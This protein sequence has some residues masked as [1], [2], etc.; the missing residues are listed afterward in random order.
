MRSIVIILVAAA[1]MGASSGDVRAA[2]HGPFGIGAV[3][4]DPT[5]VTGKLYFGDLFA[6]DFAAGVGWWGGNNVHSHVDLLLQFRL[7]QW[8]PGSLDL[9]VGVGP[10]IGWYWRG[11]RSRSQHFQV[12]VR[13]PAG[14]S[15]ELTKVPV[16]FFLEVAPGAWFVDWVDFDLDAAI[17]AR[18]YF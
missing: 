2:K 8:A 4:G 18:Y 1:L 15:F 10:K 14:V 5:G 3:L 17:G 16:E 9:Y 11:Y 7:K 6:L 13:G 12:G